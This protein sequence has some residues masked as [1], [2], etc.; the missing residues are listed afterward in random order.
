MDSGSCDILNVSDNDPDSN[1]HWW[2]KSLMLYENDKE[3]ILGDKE[4]TDS[5]VNAVQ[6]LLSAQFQHIAGFQNTI[7]G[8]NLKFK[9][10]D[11]NVLSLQILHTGM[12]MGCMVEDCVSISW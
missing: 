11:P 4:L 9:S 6:C 5:I 3:I 1:L 2:I 7:L 10:V 8:Y 12:Y